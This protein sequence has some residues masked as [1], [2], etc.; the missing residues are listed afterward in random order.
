MAEDKNYK[1]IIRVMNTDLDGSISILRALRKIKGVSFMFANMACALAGVEKTKK[2]G[3]LSDAEVQKLEA[4]FKDPVG[5]GAPEW[6]LNRR[7]DPYD[8]KSSQILSTDIR[9]IVD[10]DLKRLKMIKSYR[11][12]RH[13]AGLPARG[14]RTKANFRRHKGKSVGVKKKGK[15]R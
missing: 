12:S 13:M 8:G 11:G 2:T 10:N 14:Q 4:F 6:S 3:S 5:H 9:F 7:T 1:H 15:G